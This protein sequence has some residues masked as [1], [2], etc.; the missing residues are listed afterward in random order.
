MFTRLFSGTPQAHSLSITYFD[1][2]KKIVNNILVYNKKELGI[3]LINFN[4]S[5]LT[6]SSCTTY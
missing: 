4:D 2:R 5:T 3:L 1:R 6:Y